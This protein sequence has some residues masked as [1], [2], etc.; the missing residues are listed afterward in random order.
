MLWKV[1]RRVQPF[2]VFLYEGLGRPPAPNLSGDRWVEYSWIAANMGNG[3]GQ[4]LDFGCGKSWMGFLAARKGFDVK[5][6]D[7]EEV[8]WWYDHPCLRFDRGDLAKLSLLT[9]S[10][11]L[12][13][14]CSTVEHVGLQGRYGVAEARADGDL[15][16]MSILLHLL[17]PGKDMLLTIP[18]GQDRVFAPRHRVYGFERLPKLLSGWEVVKSEFWG[19]DEDNR[20]RV[21][22]E[23]DALSRSPLEHYYG[24]GL[25]VLRRPV[26]DQKL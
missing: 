21:C 9:D 5:A 22:E 11:D 17:K 10:F 20:W 24:L 23:K 12:I 4:A 15:E 25:F 2:L 18:V 7:L 3:P 1:T 8:R 19:K 13:I 6:I 16:A 14:N 26:K